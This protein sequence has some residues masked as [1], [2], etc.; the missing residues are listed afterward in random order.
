MYPNQQGAGPPWGSNG[1]LQGHPL[2]GPAQQQQG[3]PWGGGGGG[4][5]PFFP[6]QGA[7]GPQQQSW[8]GPQQPGAGPQQWGQPP[9]QPQQQQQQQWAQQPVQHHQTPQQP[10]GGAPAYG[11]WPAQQQPQQPQA[12]PA[13]H[14]ASPYGG[15]G[16]QLSPYHGSNQPQQSL[17]GQQGPYQQP[18][19]LHSQ[20]QQPAASPH[21]G[22]QAS[23]APYQQ[24]AWPQQ[25]QQP[26]QQPGPSQQAAAPAWSQQPAAQPQE[27]VGD[28]CKLLA[29][30]G[31]LRLPMGTLT[32]DRVPLHAQVWVGRVT[33][34][35]PPNYGIVDGDA[36]YVTQ[37]VKGSRQPVVSTASAVQQA[38]CHLATLR[39]WHPM[40]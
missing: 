32:I 34:T 1:A 40:H 4:P 38:A 27:R 31:F 21:A 33:Q 12:S 36:F 35:I 5:T 8:P 18:Q 25:A 9:A 3:Q 16:G 17:Y 28:E 23:P 6:Q 37:C 24:P 30:V 13:P 10:G 19:Q 7:A 14:Q 15:D 26:V 11:Q 29:D 20:A 2:Q 39:A 22:A